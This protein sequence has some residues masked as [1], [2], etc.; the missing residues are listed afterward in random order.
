[1]QYRLAKMSDIGNLAK[2]H[3]NVRKTYDI[4][5]FAQ[6]NI[7]FLRE[8]YR[9]LIK[10]R[11]EIILCAFDEITNEMQGFCSGTLNVAEQRRF[12]SKQKINLLVSLL[13][14]LILN[15]KLV[16]DV[17][18]RYK[19][20]NSKKNVEFQ[21]TVLDGARSEYWV[22]DNNKKNAEDSVELLNRFYNIFYILGTQE[23]F[24]EVDDSNKKVYKFHKYNGAEMVTEFLLPDKRKRIIMKYNLDKK[25]IKN[26]N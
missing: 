21:Y 7:S 14:S 15:P 2:L 4:G 24:F 10:D 1:M 19:S 23:I 17:L 6:T 18:K 9:V 13:P 20:V 3:Y 8:Y 5:F 11:N 26:G 25:F 22:W 16:F 12:F